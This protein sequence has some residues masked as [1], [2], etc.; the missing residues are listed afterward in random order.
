MLSIPQSLIYLKV[1]HMLTICIW[2]EYEQYLKAIT[3]EQH[4]IYQICT[5][6]SHVRLRWLLQSIGL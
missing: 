5:G 3:L 2:P 4:V 1:Q 6:Q